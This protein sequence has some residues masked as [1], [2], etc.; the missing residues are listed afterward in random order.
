MNNYPFDLVPP[1][2]DAPIEDNS[3]LA[4]RPFMDK[5]HSLK[6]DARYFVAGDALADAINTAIAV[7]KPFAL[8]W[9]TRN[10]QNP[11]RLLRGLASQGGIHSFPGEI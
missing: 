9:R 5:D 10:R 4:K 1:K 11:I 3:W 2:A 6:Q 8:D 7:G